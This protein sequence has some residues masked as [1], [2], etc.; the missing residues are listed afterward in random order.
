[1][2]R[3]IGLDVGDRRIGVAVSDSMRIIASPHSVYTRL[4]GNTDIE[5]FQR[6]CEELEADGY[7]LGLPRNMDGKEGSQ[8]QK[9]RDFGESLRKAGLCVEYRDE[10]LST[11]SANKALLEGGMRRDKRKMSVDMVAAALILQSRLDAPCGPGIP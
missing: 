10:R 7:V 9:T 1:M 8:A 5:Y 3:L 4:G 2:G 6:L 11:A